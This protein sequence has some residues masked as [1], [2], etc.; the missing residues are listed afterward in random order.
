MPS[1]GF[2]IIG[3][4]SGVIGEEKKTKILNF[5]E[6][7]LIDEKPPERVCDGGHGNANQ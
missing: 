3:L 6:Y 2:H 1:F 5:P 7:I 4:S